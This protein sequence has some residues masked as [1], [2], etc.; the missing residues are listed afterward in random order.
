MG[1]DNMTEQLPPGY[2]RTEI[3]IIPEDWEVKRLGEVVDV[4][5]GGTPD[6]KNPKYWGGKINWF[7]PTEIGESKYVS[8]SER[9]ITDEGL[10]HSSAKILPIGSILFTSRATIGEVAILRKEATTNQG[11]QSLIPKNIDNEFLYYLL[12]II[13]REFIAKAN[14]STFLEITPSAIKDT[15][16]S[17][18]PTI[19]EQRAIARVLSD[20]DRLIEALDELIEK[21]KMIKKGAMQELLTGKKRLPGFTGEWVRKRLGGVVD[22][23]G[24]GTPDTKNPKYWGGKINWFTPTEIGESKYVS[25]SERKITDEGLKH[26]SAKIL[27][28]GSILFTS[29]ATIGEVAILRKEA[30]TNQGFQ[31]LI[32]KNIDNEFLYYLLLIIKREFI[33]KANGSTFLEIT[34]SAIKDTEI[35]LPPTI[36]E[37]RAIARV[38]SDMDAEIEALERKKEKYERLKKGAMELLLTGKIRIKEENGKIEVVR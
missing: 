20:F 4:V 23:V 27:P 37:Q 15:E 30:T 12:L 38:L 32:P 13:K 17:L 18:P 24:G 1:E 11:F 19:E 29:R 5:G 25:E 3:G 35:S 28:I 22:I 2:R 10:K 36:E 26:S 16:I 6:T 8:E 31:S 34:P 21:K 9:K 14:G 33:A 7:T